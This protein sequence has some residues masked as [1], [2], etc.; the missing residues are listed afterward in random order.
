MLRVRG[1]GVLGITREILLPR[2]AEKWPNLRISIKPPQ[3]KTNF[4]ENLLC[5]FGYA[6]GAYVD[7]GFFLMAME[8]DAL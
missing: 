7:V 2:K 6:Y 1:T 5:G 8:V 4:D 3:P